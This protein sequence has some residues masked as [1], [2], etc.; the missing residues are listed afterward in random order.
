[1]ADENG[2]NGT[3]RRAVLKRIGAGAA[4]AWTAPALLSVGSRAVAGTAQPCGPIDG[5]ALVDCPDCGVC[6]QLHGGGGTVCF[7]RLTCK[8]DVPICSNDADC[9]ALS[10]SSA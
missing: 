3:S 2:L 4:V 5:A 6:G 8:T 7:S 10:D 1:M 9:E